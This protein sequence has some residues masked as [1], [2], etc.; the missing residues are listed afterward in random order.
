VA[1][2]YQQVCIAELDFIRDLIPDAS[3]ERVTHKTE[4]AHTCAYE[5]TVHE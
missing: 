4:G 1:N 5:I 3:V 2:R